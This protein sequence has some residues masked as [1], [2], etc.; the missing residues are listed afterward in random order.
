LLG[1]E[2]DAVTPGAVDVAR[3]IGNFASVVD[4]IAQTAIE[5]SR[6]TAAATMEVTELAKGGGHQPGLATSPAPIS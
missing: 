4:F 5:N 2:S 3:V 6:L 1:N